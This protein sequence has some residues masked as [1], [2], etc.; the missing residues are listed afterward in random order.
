M[1]KAVSTAMALPSVFPLAILRS[2]ESFQS[3]FPAEWTS[4]RLTQQLA[5]LTKWSQW[6]FAGTLLPWGERLLIKQLAYPLW[7]WFGRLSVNDRGFPE[8]IS[9]THFSLAAQNKVALQ[10]AISQLMDRFISLVCSTL[11]DVAGHPLQTFV[12]ATHLSK[13]EQNCLHHPITALDQ[14]EKPAIMQRRHCCV[15]IHL[16]NEL[17]ISCPLDRCPS[18]KNYGKDCEQCKTFRV[19]A[20]I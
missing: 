16:D 19:R 10:Q 3:L 9:V 7:Q 11:S 15:R 12:N 20:A 5:W 1:S 6:F 14:A 18:S 4:Y 2:S 17:G 13:G 8:P